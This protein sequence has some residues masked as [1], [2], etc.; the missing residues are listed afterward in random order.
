MKKIAIITD[1][2][3]SLPPNIANQYGI[4]QVPITVQFGE[5]SYI[6]GVDINDAQLFEKVAQFNKLPTTSAPS[7]GMFSQAFQ[8]SFDNG[9]D[10]IVCI[11]VSSKVS[12]TYNSALNA[13]E[14]FPDREIAVIDS[15]NLSMGQGFMV[16]AA[17][18]AAQAGAT[19]EEM[20]AWTMDINTRIYTYA[21]LPTL[22]YLAMS[23][24]VGKFVAGMADTF[25][26]KP[27]LTIQDG[28]L[29]LLE[30][31]RTQKN[32]VQRIIELTRIALNGKAIERAA[33]IHVNNLD[34]ARA[35]QEQLC[36]VVPCPESIIIAEF[37]PGLSVHAGSGVVGIVTVAVA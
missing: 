20:I 34:G 1:T 13:C 19:K 9:A 2:D 21:A 12:A 7:I 35:L 31:V 17:A 22:K 24:R 14:M 32:A 8:T 16:L 29:D 27:V 5:E 28:K 25:N 6:T 3:S 10:S 23:G 15:L 36:A 30:K 4:Q 11:C 33:I 26:I 37:T 18:E